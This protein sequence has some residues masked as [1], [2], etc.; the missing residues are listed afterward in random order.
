[1]STATTG[2]P[3]DA[4]QDDP[5][6]ALR[7]PVIPNPYP[8][9]KYEVAL[10]IPDGDLWGP[11]LRPDDAEARQVAAYIEYRMEYY[12][13]GWKAKMRQRPL[14]TDATTNTTILMK[15]GEGDWCYRRASWQYGPLMVPE[16]DGEHLDLER[17]LDLINDLV[18][19]KWQAWKDAHPE[20]FGTG[21]EQQ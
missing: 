10:V 16:R 7:I 3:Y 1:M 13:D 14:D 5:L 8:G 12:N 11:A 2:W 21:K 6:T 18:P 20:A 17:L 19:A 15:R 9:W 4:R